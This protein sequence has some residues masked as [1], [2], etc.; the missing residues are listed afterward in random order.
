MATRSSRRT[1][2]CVW[3]ESHCLPVSEAILRT[4]TG[5]TLGWSPR[6]VRI[7]PIKGADAMHEKVIMRGI[8]VGKRGAEKW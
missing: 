2:L 8:V 1:N 6:C 3:V 5:A 4:T 7:Q